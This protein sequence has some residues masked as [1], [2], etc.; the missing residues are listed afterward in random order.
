MAIS[1]AYRTWIN[2]VLPVWARSQN[3]MIFYKFLVVDFTG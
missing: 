1:K 3:H 2:P